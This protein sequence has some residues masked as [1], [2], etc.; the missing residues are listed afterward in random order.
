MSEEVW[1]TA[2]EREIE[3]AIA[4]LTKEIEKLTV[5]ETMIRMALV[6]HRGIKE[7]LEQR[8]ATLRNNEMR[9]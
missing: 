4:S 5:Q 1:A 7:S 8:L 6:R 9:K 3:L 2:S